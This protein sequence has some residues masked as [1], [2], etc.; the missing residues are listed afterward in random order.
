MG[1]I[2]NI[3]LVLITIA[4]STFAHAE[5]FGV[6]KNHK[7]VSSVYE[8]TTKTAVAKGYQNPSVEEVT[9]SY[10]KLDDLYRVD[11]KSTKTTEIGDESKVEDV[12]VTAVV[13]DTKGKLSIDSWTDTTCKASVKID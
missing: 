11:L 2:N 9:Q 5:N 1:F 7:R 3:L 10:N 8:Y 13:R 6:L 4:L 12:C